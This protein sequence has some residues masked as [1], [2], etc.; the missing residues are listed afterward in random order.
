MPRDP[1]HDILFEPIQIGPKLMKNRFYQ[2]PHCIGAGSEKPGTQAANRAMKAEGGWGACCTE[3]CSIHPESDDTHRVSARLW[4]K[5]DVVNLRHMNDSLHAHG[6]LGGIE[7]WYGGAHAPNMESRAVPL[8]PS[9]YASEFEYLTYSHEADE[10]EIKRLINHYV[11]AAKR[12]VQAGFDIIY[13]YGGH[14]YLPLQFLSKFYNRRT[15][16]YGGSLDNRAR[17]W[18][19]SLTAVKAA[20]GNE[21]AVATRFAIDT[22]YGMDGVEVGDDGLKF[23]ELVDKEGVLDLW[24]INIG[25][26][27]EWG[28]DAGP[29]R[30]YKAG[31][32][33]N[34][35][36]EATR[37]A[38][39][40]V[41]GVS[42][43]TSPDDMAARLREGRLDILGFARPSIADPFLPNKVNEGRVEDIRECIG[44]NVCISR[45]EIGG[46]PMICT[47]NATANEEY[48]R[49]WHPE[50]FAATKAPCSVLVVGA[51]PAGMECARV[52]GERGYD[53]HLREAEDEVGGRVRKVQRYPGLSEWGRVVSYR[54]IQLTKLSKLKKVEIHTGVGRMS[55][56]DV[57]TYGADKV[58]LATG[59]RWASDGLSMVNHSPV[60]GIDA[61]QPWCI[62]PE[63]L[64][65][66]GKKAGQNVLVLDA[67]GYFTG[68]S[69][70]E[71][72]AD[73]GK[74]VTIITPLGHVAPYTHFTLEGPN[75]RRMMYE[76]GIHEK[77][78]HWVEKVEPGKATV[79]FLYRDGY[80][81]DAGPT[82]GKLPRRAGTDVIEMNFDS[83]VVCTARV[84]NNEVYLGLK[85]RKAEWASNEL[86]GV[87]Q[88][89]DCF[90]PRLIADAIFEGHRIAR[91][92]ESSNPQFAQPWIRERQVWGHE[93]F[94]KLED[95]E[96]RG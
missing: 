37:V 19:E 30:F 38:K 20:V 64:M 4:D 9:S 72:L 78:Y 57:L 74:K 26:I 68:V 63:Q 49:G 6:A 21:A 24:D 90:A 43:E 36:D 89:G 23:V 8:G 87:Y 94:P 52:L 31:H 95:R 5:G 66:G 54:Q 17:F 81:R 86:L 84:P 10:D 14:S 59:S 83:I 22:L 61:S 69:C 45:W 93:T 77:T 34:W 44:C 41:L 16:K 7:M 46:P 2:V 80:V 13:V 1:K 60:P 85:A 40:P 73:Q 65:L 70:A 53:V 15:D 25:D 62:T 3:Y 28:E 27:A 47:Q 32:Q 12:A 48:R 39:V 75:L 79:Y 71:Y 56:E 67:D 76:K 42:R 11:E 55:A 33:R 29:S 58:V 18:I 51:G 50:R 88:A 92:F 96:T 35:T 82:T 91:E